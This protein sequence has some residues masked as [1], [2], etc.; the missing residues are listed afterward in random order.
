M[1]T[2]S[3]IIVTIFL[4]S[5]IS[6]QD[7]QLFDFGYE[8]NRV[9]PDISIT[10]A[11]LSDAVA[12]S[13]LNRFFKTKWVEEYVSVNIIVF[14][15]GKTLEAKSDD[16]KLTQEQKEIMGKADIGRNIAV[17][18]RYYPDNSLLDKEIKAYDFS[19]IIDPNKEASFIGGEEAMRNYFDKNIMS[20]I[21]S[22]KFKQHKL[23]AVNFTISPEGD[24]TDVKLYDTS[25]YDSSVELSLETFLTES[26]CN[27]PK[28]NPAEYSNGQKVSQDLAFSI[29]DHYS[30]TVNELN[31]RRYPV[32]D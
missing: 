20:Q 8:V 25:M 2:I 7:K 6:A 1:K 12:V 10:E 32:E 23:R 17:E 22:S 19:F 21:D 5:N 24:V 29:G 30:C 31:I 26:I 4:L 18:I 27:M 14:S 13:D 15:D 11:E 28:W 9:L 16:N 3:A